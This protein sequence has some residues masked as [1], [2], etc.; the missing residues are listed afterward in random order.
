MSSFFKESVK[1]IQETAFNSL[2]C[3]DSMFTTD[4]LNCKSILGYEFHEVNQQLLII[5]Q[6]YII[7]F[8]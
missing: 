1:E 6:I 2:M 7:V 5:C 8:T 3:T 4:S